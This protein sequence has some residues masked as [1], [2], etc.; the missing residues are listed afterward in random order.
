MA[1]G[2]AASIGAG[3]ML[4]TVWVSG[5]SRALAAP[6]WQDV[7]EQATGGRTARIDSYRYEGDELVE[8]A[9]SYLRV[10]ATVRSY[11]YEP[12]DGEM[13]RTEGVIMTPDG[14]VQWNPRTKLARHVEPDDRYVASPDYAQ[15]LLALIGLSDAHGQAESQ[16]EINGEDA[17]FVRVGHAH[18]KDASLRGFEL[19]TTEGEPALPGPYASLV[20]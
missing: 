8:R 18:P 11:E 14:G 16:I 5:P 9:E 15:T 2:I 7:V 10:P 6:T 12:I 13:T 1:C 4:L 19:R 20:Y 3:L 17:R